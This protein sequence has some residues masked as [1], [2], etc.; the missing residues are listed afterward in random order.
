MLNSLKRETHRKQEQEREYYRETKEYNSIQSGYRAT[1]TL[2]QPRSGDRN[3]SCHDPSMIHTAGAVRTMYLLKRS[4]KPQYSG[5]QE[6]I[7][8]VSFMRN[9]PTVGAANHITERSAPA[10]S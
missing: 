9:T 2:S 3:F 1:S 4:F 6:L 10:T 8:K 5:G 7:G